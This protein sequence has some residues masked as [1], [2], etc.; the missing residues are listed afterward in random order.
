MQLAQ[1]AKMIN[2]GVLPVKMNVDFV[3]KIHVIKMMEN[4]IL[5]V[6]AKIKHI[7]EICV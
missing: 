2:T 5:M 7:M 1:N 3:L 4:V 6:I